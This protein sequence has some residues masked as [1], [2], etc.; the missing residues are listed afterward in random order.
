MPVE[1]LFEPPLKE[2]LD[3]KKKGMQNKEI[4]ETLEGGYYPSEISEAITQA[5]IKA[6]SPIELEETAPSP[7]A[8]EEIEIEKPQPI[9]IQAQPTSFREEYR[10]VTGVQEQ[11]EEITEAIVKEKLE[12][13]SSTIT[14]LPAWREST[15]TDV[16]ALKQE[17][18]RLEQRFDNLQKA[19]LGRVAEYDKNVTDVSSD[20]KALEK[21]F[22]N[23]L[24]PLTTNVKE[25]Q[26]LT[27]KVKKHKGK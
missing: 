10:P 4:V 11:I 5:D 15:R 13:L 3:L 27:E 17:L 25:L 18:L 20:I 21:V 16:I 23:I 22:K 12:E 2:V 19:I 1:D 24:E 8:V 26:E 7:S 14:D 6:A 9:P